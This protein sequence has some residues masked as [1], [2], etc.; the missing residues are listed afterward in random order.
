MTIIVKR[1]GWGELVGVLLGLFIGLLSASLAQ[2]FISQQGPDQAKALTPWKGICAQTQ[3]LALVLE[4]QFQAMDT[5]LDN[6]ETQTAGLIKGQGDILRHFSL[7]PI[8]LM[9]IRVVPTIPLIDE[10]DLREC[11]KE[12]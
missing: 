8:G 7:P 3:Q 10:W 5:C 11:F 12:P 4:Q 1:F 6:I 9:T 2:K